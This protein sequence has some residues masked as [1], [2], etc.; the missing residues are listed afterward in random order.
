MEVKAIHLY[1]FLSI[2]TSGD[3]NFR[4]RNFII[5]RDVKDSFVYDYVYT[6]MHCDRFPGAEVFDMERCRCAAQSVTNLVPPGKTLISENNKEMGCFDSS[7][8]IGCPRR[9]FK[10]DLVIE[11]QTR[12]DI[13]C[14]E[15]CTDIK[16]IYL[17]NLDVAIYNVRGSWLKF[18]AA[19]IDYFLIRK[20]TTEHYMDLSCFTE[21]MKKLS[22]GNLV[23]FQFKRGECSTLKFK[24]EQ[25]FPKIVVNIVKEM[26]RLFQKKPTNCVSTTMKPVATTTTT[27][28][29][30]ST[31][32]TTST[33]AT[34]ISTTTTTITQKPPT[35]QQSFRITANTLT[36][37]NSNSPKPTI[38]PTTKPGELTTTPIFSTTPL[39]VSKG[40]EKLS[41][42]FM[43]IVIA[44]GVAFVFILVIVVAF[45]IRTRVQ[46]T[47]QTK[48]KIQK[49]S[50]EDNSKTTTEDDKK[51]KKITL[52]RSAEY[53]LKA[54]D[55]NADNSQSNPAKINP[56][57][58]Q[59]NLLNWNDNMIYA[60]S[61]Q[62]LPKDVTAN[63]GSS[64]D[65][66]YQHTSNH[67]RT[68]TFDD[69]TY[70]YA[71]VHLMKNTP[72]TSVRKYVK[73]ENATPILHKKNEPYTPLAVFQVGQY[74]TH[75][76]D[77]GDYIND[78]QYLDLPELND[79]KLNYKKPNIKNPSY[80]NLRKIKK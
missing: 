41:V 52:G 78:A 75:Q 17:W 38:K 80:T 73:P 11:G 15:K 16:N 26:N 74:Q 68:R 46:N 34:T 32:T 76:G 36:T 1:F 37:P 5:R 42:E 13:L 53:Y 21:N 58:N 23:K 77:A 49:L 24:G 64:G 62:N 71:S 60:S 19:A 48:A 8:H 54:I 22:K 70:E 45:K 47:R 31:A 57:V 56:P 67:E 40:E 12:V 29:R 14:G 7:I 33:T 20:T 72:V 63:K 51:D 25:P 30:P 44:F 35:T 10:N 9:V 18:P 39:M 4:K 66:G 79:Y 50:H 65:F 27:T 61:N 6:Q 43:Y 59:D 55:Y 69:S 28:G 2:L 3:G